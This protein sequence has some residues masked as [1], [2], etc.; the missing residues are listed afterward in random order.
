MPDE[1]TKRIDSE[2]MNERL[3]QMAEHADIGA[4]AEIVVFCKGRPVY[5]HLSQ[6]SSSMGHV[7]VEDVDEHN[8]RILHASIGLVADV[9]KVTEP[10]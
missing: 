7:L 3:L 10:V 9:V 1:E 4:D 6:G 5:H 2:D 8:R